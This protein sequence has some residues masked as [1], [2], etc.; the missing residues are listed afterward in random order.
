[1]QGRPL[2]T[3]IS[4][5]RL[6]YS[7]NPFINL[8]VRGHNVMYTATKMLVKFSVLSKTFYTNLGH[9]GHVPY[10]RVSMNTTIICLF[11]TEGSTKTGTSDAHLV[12]GQFADN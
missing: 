9:L 6:L 5:A 4:H 11:T 7:P 1:M 8:C 10:F 12:T 3:A 2:L